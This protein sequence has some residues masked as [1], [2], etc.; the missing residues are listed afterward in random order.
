V[1]YGGRYLVD[2]VLRGV[3][4]VRTIERF[5]DPALRWTRDRA[6]QAYLEASYHL[7]VPPER[8][9]MVA[10]HKWDLDGAAQAR[11]KTIYVPRPRKIR[12]RLEETWGARRKE[13][14]STWW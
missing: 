6:T 9:A 4:A 12:A 3:Q 11:L 10:A 1:S 13:G 8:V 2:R 14:M 5:G 7:G